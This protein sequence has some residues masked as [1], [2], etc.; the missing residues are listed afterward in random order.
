[1]DHH[2]PSKLKEGQH[3]SWHSPV[4]TPL[5]QSLVNLIQKLAKEIPLDSSAGIYPFFCFILDDHIPA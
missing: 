4:S 3:P 2:D 5:K 1:M